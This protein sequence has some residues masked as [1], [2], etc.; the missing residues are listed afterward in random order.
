MEQ[1]FNDNYLI[2]KVADTHL[3]AAISYPLSRD[4]R[5]YAAEYQGLSKV[6][7]DKSVK[8]FLFAASRDHITE[9]QSEEVELQI[10][11]LQFETGDLRLSA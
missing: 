7:D 5:Q 6:P 4:I 9:V 8:C 3:Y 1:F 10:N 2:Y 11:C